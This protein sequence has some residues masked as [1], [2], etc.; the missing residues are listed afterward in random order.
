M[1]ERQFVPFAVRT[2]LLSPRCNGYQVRNKQRKSEVPSNYDV[3]LGHTSKLRPNDVG[4]WPG[5]V[6]PA[7]IPLFL[8]AAPPSFRSRI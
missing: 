4:K 6:N 7:P 1:R 5:R 2:I 3:A 8:T